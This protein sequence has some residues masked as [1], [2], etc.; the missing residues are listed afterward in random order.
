MT[1]MTSA[2]R[3]DEQDG[4]PADLQA[5]V[6]FSDPAL[7]DAGGWPAG[8]DDERLIFLVKALAAA[9]LWADASAVAVRIGGRLPTDRA[10]SI[11][12]AQLQQRSALFA[13]LAPGEALKWLRPVVTFAID[14]GLKD[15]ERIIRAIHTNH[16]RHADLVASIACEWFA[17]LRRFE[18]SV[19]AFQGGMQG[20]QPDF[21]TA[22]F[23]RVALI[24]LGKSVEA[25]AFLARLA[26]DSDC[27]AMSPML[28]LDCA[29]ALAQTAENARAAEIFTALQAETFGDPPRAVPAD[30][31]R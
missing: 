1:G 23:Y 5:G 16:P 18:Q 4:G 15:P 30:I 9:G 26:L 13:N 14:A 20:G 12:Q 19:E 29:R 10:R 6:V 3:Q 25:E 27:T 31:R 8:W 11:S 2:S 22:E 28:A 7:S 21:T 17:R 24:G